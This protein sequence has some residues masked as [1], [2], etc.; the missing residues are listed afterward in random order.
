MFRPGATRVLSRTAEAALTSRSARS[1]GWPAVKDRLATLNAGSLSR[2]CGIRS[3]YRRFVYRTRASL[4]HNDTAKRLGWSGRL[5]GLELRLSHCGLARRLVIQSS[6]VFHGGCG[7]YRLLSHGCGNR[8]CGS[9]WLLHARRGS[10]S[11]NRRFR[12]YGFMHWR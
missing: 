11:L 5:R 12:Q 8:S 6:H 7:R 10:D 1:T 4:R 3:G 2:R 9:G